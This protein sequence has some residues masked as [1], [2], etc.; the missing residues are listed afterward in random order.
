M[1]LGGK[2]I[3]GR[4]RHI[5]V[6][7]GIAIRVHVVIMMILISKGSRITFQ[8]VVSIIGRVAMLDRGIHFAIG[9]SVHAWIASILLMSIIDSSSLLQQ[10]K[11]LRKGRSVVE[12]LAKGALGDADLAKI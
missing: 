6:K 11:V 2:D 10:V 1:L 9:S 7:T 3:D 8:I 5:N 4:K 12:M